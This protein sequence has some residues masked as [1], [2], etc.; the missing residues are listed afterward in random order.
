M[1]S[2]LNF[3]LIIISQYICLED[4]LSWHLNEQSKLLLP[5]RINSI[6]LTADIIDFPLKK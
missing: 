4:G 6:C 2:V 1:L 5:A 3:L